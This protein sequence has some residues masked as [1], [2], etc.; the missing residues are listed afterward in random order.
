MSIIKSCKIVGGTA[1]SITNS[2]Q[3]IDTL[4]YGNNAN[5]NHPKV[6]GFSII[7]RGSTQMDI[8]INNGDIMTIEAG[9]GRTYSE[10]VEIF[11]CVIKTN[12]AVYQWDG[13]LL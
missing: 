7:N 2:T 8:Q 4:L 6:V 5:D 11:S 12:G 13:I 1:V 10:N 3:L 9:E